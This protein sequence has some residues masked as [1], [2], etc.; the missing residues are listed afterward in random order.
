MRGRSARRRR[1]PAHQLAGGWRWRCVGPGR[2]A[3]DRLGRPPKSTGAGAA[4]PTHHRSNVL[5]TRRRCAAHSPVRR[6]RNHLLSGCPPRPTGPGV[7]YRAARW[8]R[9]PRRDAG[10]PNE[11]RSAVGGSPRRSGRVRWP[12]QQPG[13]QPHPAPPDQF[14]THIQ[15]KILACRSRPDSARRSQRTTPRRSGQHL[16][17]I[18]VAAEFADNL[19]CGPNLHVPSLEAGK[20]GHVRSRQC[21]WKFLW[22]SRI[23]RRF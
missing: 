11:P 14:R 6:R 16:R 23:G 18:R 12:R 20:G 3:P 2:P 13:C 9:P 5:Q 17:T 4:D 22:L 15:Y 10:R 1:W 21:A 8:R 7:Q 19:C